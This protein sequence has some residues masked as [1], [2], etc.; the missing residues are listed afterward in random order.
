MAVATEQDEVREMVRAG[1]GERD[2]VMD[3]EILG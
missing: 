2:D 1:L 3:L